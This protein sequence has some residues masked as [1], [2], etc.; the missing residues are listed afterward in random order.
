MANTPVP[1]RPG[2]REIIEKNSILVAKDILVDLYDSSKKLLKFVGGF[3][4]NVSK[5]AGKMMAKRL[6]EQGYM[7]RE[8]CL[9]VLAESFVISGYAEEV[10]VEGDTIKM[11]GTIFGSRMKGEKKP[12]DTPIAGFIAGWVEECTGKRVKVVEEK[13]IAKGDEYCE[14]RIQSSRFF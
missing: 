8:T 14:F 12:V 11:K 6:M 5:K 1:G 10:K 2:L 3:L 13:C 4:Y 9:D 7:T